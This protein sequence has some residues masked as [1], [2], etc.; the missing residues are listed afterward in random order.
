M[1]GD[2]IYWVSVVK[3]IKGERDIVSDGLSCVGIELF[4]C[5]GVS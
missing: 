5:G 3:I 1:P 4:V 2:V